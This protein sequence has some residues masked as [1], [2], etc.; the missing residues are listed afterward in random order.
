[1]LCTTCSLRRPLRTHIVGRS[2][3]L[4]SNAHKML[5]PTAYDVRPF[6]PKGKAASQGCTLKTTLRNRE[7]VHRFALR[8]CG[9]DPVWS[10]PF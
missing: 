8:A 7:F 3:A 9:N 5:T 1:M 6:Y 2:G 10:S 4:K